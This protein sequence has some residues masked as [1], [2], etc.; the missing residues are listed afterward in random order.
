MGWSSFWGTLYAQF[1]EGIYPAV[2]ERLELLNGTYGEYLRWSF[3]VPT[4]QGEAI[5]VSG[6]T[7]TI[8]NNRSKFYTWAS[9]VKRKPFSEGE[10]L[11]TDTL[12]SQRCRVYLTIKELD[13][14]RSINQV[15]KVLPAD[16]DPT[17]VVEKD[18]DAEEYPF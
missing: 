17:F 1:K 14:G 3:M 8:F 5:S 10:T 7:S 12:H 4:K 11:D 13:G 18:E 15:E 2:V 6:L 16:E 9:A